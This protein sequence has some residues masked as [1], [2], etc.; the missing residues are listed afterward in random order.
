MLC[1]LLLGGL[2]LVPSL[3][4]RILSLVRVKSYISIKNF[5]NIC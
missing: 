4:V 3:S 1:F 2:D 5:S